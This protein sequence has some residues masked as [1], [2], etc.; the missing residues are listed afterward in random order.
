MTLDA[1]SEMTRQHVLSVPKA[2]A[3]GVAGAADLMTLEPRTSNP[4]VD[5]ARGQ[6]FLRS[7]SPGNDANTVL[8][9][10]FDGAG[11]A[12]N[13]SAAIPNAITVLGDTFQSATT[14]KFGGKAGFFDG[15]GDSLSIAENGAFDLG[16]GDFTVDAWVYPT[17]LGGDGWHE[18][19]SCY[20][21]TLPRWQL[22]IHSTGYLQTNIN[23]GSADHVCAS[24]AGDV[25]ANQWTHVALVRSGNTLKLYRNGAQVQSCGLTQQVNCSASDIRVGR[26]HTANGG[27]HYLFGYLNELRVSKGVARWTAP[28]TPPT[29]AYGSGGLFFMSPDGKV[30]L[31]A[32]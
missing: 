30:T 28:F 24:A 16:A 19:I 31:L 11:A 5:P 18:I 20:S 27:P 3:G 13:D 9:L 6:L 25:T 10:H 8:L 14:S 4:V 2:A 22:I 29:A 26:G 23:D 21:T 1:G 32:D 15:N 7:G 17:T 12:M